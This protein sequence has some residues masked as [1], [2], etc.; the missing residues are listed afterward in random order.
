[1]SKDTVSLQQEQKQKLIELGDYLRQHREGYD[2]TLEDVAEKTRIQRR[3]LNAIEQGNLHQL[4]EPVYVK[5]LLRRYADAMGLD[6]GTIANAFPTEPD[7]R[8]IKPSWKDSPAAQLRPI[9]LYAAYILLIM[10]AVSGL[11]YL[12]NRSTSWMPDAD[13]APTEAPIVSEVPNATTAPTPEANSE[14]TT[15]N[16]PEIPD[17]SEGAMSEA[18]VPEGQVRVDITLTDRSW[19]RVNVDGETAFQGVLPEGT[20]RSWTAENTLTLR[21]GNAGAVMLSYN[22]GQAERMGEPG[23]VEELTFPGSQQQAARPDDETATP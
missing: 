21:A 10:A 3:L 4:P 9:H 20:R 18:P 19:L 23:A 12:L 1:M 8:A 11:S 16:R 13:V 22:N 15:T 6:G 14:A 17:I 2:L 5:A 7:I